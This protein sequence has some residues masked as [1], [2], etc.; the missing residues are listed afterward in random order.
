MLE[1]NQPFDLS[2]KGILRCARY[3]FMPNRL[4]F[5][6]PDKNQDL[7]Y[8]SSS[9]AVDPGL[10]LILKEFQTLYPYL[11]LIARANQIK[12]VFD[13]RVVEAY[14]LGN[15]LLENIAQS[16]F[17]SHLKDGLSLRKKLN[18]K[19]F[20]KASHKIH[21]G[22]KP[23]HNFHVLSIWKRTGN[24]DIGHTLSSMDLCRISWAKIKRVN[25]SELEVEHQP[26]EIENDKLGLGLPVIQ[27]AL[28]QIDGSGFIQNLR[29]G[30]WVSLHWNFACEIL[31]P[32]QVESL[33]K[34][35]QES[36]DLVNASVLK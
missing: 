13:Q 4:K 20:R 15:S 2:Q 14:W 27:K 25:H 16:E 22:A 36:I 23:H 11:K 34:Y 29:I 18:L 35:T 33:K 12:D 32:R 7:F 21:L 28:Y 26:L 10:S 6:G 17:Y 1:K 3:A 30:Q 9:Q 5:C 31:N 8:Y 19:D 24:L